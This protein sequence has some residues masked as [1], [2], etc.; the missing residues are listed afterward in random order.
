LFSIPHNGQ[1][2]PKA[3]HLAAF[4]NAGLGGVVLS[5]RSKVTQL[6]MQNM[7]EKVEMFAGWDWDSSVI[8]GRE[9]NQ[10]LP[11][12]CTVVVHDD[13]AE[14]VFTES[15]VKAILRDLLAAA[16]DG[17]FMPNYDRMDE[18]VRLHGLSFDPA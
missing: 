16:E 10:H 18:M 4:G 6:K 7:A 5:G 11:N 3:A 1:A 8:V 14:R 2:L 17:P 9:M 12:R 15:E 13:K